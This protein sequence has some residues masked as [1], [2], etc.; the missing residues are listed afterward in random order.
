MRGRRR[1]A[2]AAITARPRN[3]SDAVTLMLVAAC[4]AGARVVIIALDPVASRMAY[5]EPP[6]VWFNGSFHG[7]IIR[8]GLTLFVIFKTSAGRNWARIAFLALVVAQTPAALADVLGPLKDARLWPLLR[9]AHLALP[10]IACAGLFWGDA[11][12]WFRPCR[13]ALAMNAKRTR[14]ARTD[15]AGAR[16]DSIA[17]T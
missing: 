7:A 2:R 14:T 1:S 10:I 12:A 9:A 11:S 16:P 3:V 8:L 4:V 6:N 5:G 15:P 13:T 17:S